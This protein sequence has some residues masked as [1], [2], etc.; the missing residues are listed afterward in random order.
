MKKKLISALIFILLYGGIAFAVVWLLNLGG[1]YPSGADTMGYIHKADV[2]FDNLLEGRLFSLYDEYWYNGVQT[3]R[4]SAILPVYILALLRMV[5]GDLIE[6]Y[7]L[8][9]G[10]VFLFGAAVWLFAGIDTDRPVLG[11]IIGIIWFFMPNNMYA[12]FVEGNLGRAVAMII[13]PFLVHMICEYIYE[14]KN[15]TVFISLAMMLLVLCGSGYALMTGVAVFVFMVIFKLANSDKRKFAGVFGPMV[16]GT[17]MAGVWLLPSL[18]GKIELKDTSQ[19]INSYFQNIGVTLNPILRFDLN[20]EAYY[21]GVAAFAIMIFGLIASKKKSIPGFAVA[22]IILIMT[23]ST[24]YDLLVK[25]PGSKYLLMLQ[26][27]SIALCFILYSLIQWETLRKSIVLAM[28]L[29]LILDAVPSFSLLFNGISDENATAKLEKIEADTLL[30]Q[31]KSITKQR[32]AFIDNGRY[33]STASFIMSDYGEKK[34]KETFG[35]EWTS[36]STARNIVLLNEATENGYYDYLFDRALGLGNDTVLIQKEDLYYGESDEEFVTKAA[37]KSGYKKVS[38]NAG[39]LLYHIDTYDT[40]G[41]VTTYDYIG[42]GSSSGNM[43]LVYPNMKET[44]DSNLNH[45]TFEELSKYKLVY[46]DFFTYDNKTAAEKLIKNLADAGVKI[47]INADGIPEDK[48]LML[49]EFLGVTTNTIVFENG[50]PILYMDNDEIDC[51]LFAR[52]YSD[53]R[54]VY[55]NGCDKEIG[56]LWDHDVKECFL[57]TVYNDNITIVGLNLSFHLYLTGDVNVAR[58]FED[59]FETQM[60]ELPQRQIVPIEVETS[61]HKIRIESEYDNVC[62][63]VAYHDIFRGEELKED[64]SLLY[65]DAGK[66]LITMKYP[67]LIPGLVITLLGIAFTISMFFASGKRENW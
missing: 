19:L 53:W 2:L 1:K 56:T 59:I 47:V 24:V 38:E 5:T 65:V 61:G 6:A 28:I 63:S 3:V 46:L 60:A 62:T 42:I 33:A 37:E 66:T 57:G 50:Y 16:S 67:Y 8:F 13:L 22:L 25:I 20:N 18:I 45:Y 9:V 12:L 48:A 35:N 51:N 29:L 14:D 64:Y 36:A 40:F 31:A 55:M 41:T 44:E 17:M 15:R 49:P 21:F 23:T 39:Y 30:G 58:I 54:T 52:G 27:I 26:F 7:R 34:I 10:F 11:G 32:I 4:Y 43:S